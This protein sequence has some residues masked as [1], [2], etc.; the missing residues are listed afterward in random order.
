MIPTYFLSRYSIPQFPPKRTMVNVLLHWCCTTQINLH[1]NIGPSAFWK[2]VNARP[3]IYYVAG[4]TLQSVASR[5]LTVSL[6]ERREKYVYLVQCPVEQH[7][8]GRSKTR[9][10]TN[11][12]SWKE[13]TT[14]GKDV[15]FKDMLQFHLLGRIYLPYKL[16][17]PNDAGM[18]WWRCHG[19]K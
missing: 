10:V 16:K 4:W 5:A 8:R 14:S 13:D 7:N 11:L 18:R 19:R 15:Y 17:H 1:T 2:R 6:Q 9:K 12:S 3:K